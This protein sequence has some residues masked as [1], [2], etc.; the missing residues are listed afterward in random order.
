[1]SDRTGLTGQVG[2]DRSDLPALNF[3]KRSC[4]RRTVAVS[5]QSA[6]IA[7]LIL[8]AGGRYRVGS[9]VAWMLLQSL[10]VFPSLGN[11]SGFLGGC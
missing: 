1:M 4:F 11:G 8:T 6:V 7:A 3:V 5:V 2:Q 10:A 9:V